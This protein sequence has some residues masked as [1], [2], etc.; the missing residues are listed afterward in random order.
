MRLLCLF[1]LCAVLSSASGGSAKQTSASAIGT[2]AQRAP[3]SV[4]RPAPGPS[5]SPAP[6][7]AEPFLNFFDD[8]LIP[9]LYE[10]IKDAV[11]E[12]YARQFAPGRSDAV[13]HAAKECFFTDLDDDE[14]GVVD[15]TEVKRMVEPMFP[16]GE[17]RLE[18][19]MTKVLNGCAT[20]GAA[21]C[22][23]QTPGG[24]ASY[25][26][27]FDQF[28]R[29]VRSSGIV[30]RVVKGTGLRG[31]GNGGD[32]G[33]LKTRAQEVAFGV[34]AS[35]FSVAVG[36][37]VGWLRREASRLRDRKGLA[38]AG[39]TYSDAG[40]TGDGL[41]DS[42]GTG[43]DADGDGATGGGGGAG[44]NDAGGANNNV[45]SSHLAEVVT[46]DDEDEFVDE[47]TPLLSRKASTTD[48]IDAGAG[49]AGDGE[50]EGDGEDDEPLLR[51]DGE[52]RT[53][54]ARPTS[55]TNNNNISTGVSTGSQVRG[56]GL[57][58]FGCAGRIA[59]PPPPPRQLLELTRPGPKLDNPQVLIACASSWPSG[60]AASLSAV[61]RTCHEHTKLQDFC[62]AF[63]SF[64]ISKEE[65]DEASSSDSD[66][67]AAF[68]PDDL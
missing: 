29:F 68:I 18:D 46:D 30:D 7:A 38:P 36:A 44:G 66:D 16:T 48:A 42:S 41:A 23:A 2:P 60:A 14:S 45:S 43:G 59:A 34:V 53:P 25:V 62:S 63:A 4:L 65:D 27:T 6:A 49:R 67:D 61:N 47:E 55:P 1:T 54:A 13:E 5:P 31:A 9:K 37:I 39:N 17:L 56:G 52:Q 8:K 58:F 28:L 35:F 11:G 26:T 20:L 51:F 22:H 19:L 64:G 15:A 57:G 3:A 40:S 33:W 32:G 12:C 24:V 10:V 50:D 21:G